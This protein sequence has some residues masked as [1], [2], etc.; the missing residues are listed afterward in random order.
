ML[1]CMKDFQLD[2]YFYF[3]DAK[4][5]GFLSNVSLGFGSF[6]RFK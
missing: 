4:Y 2:S 3:S 1:I 6:L 5:C